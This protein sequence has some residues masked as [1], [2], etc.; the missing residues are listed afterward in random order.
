MDYLIALGDTFSL[1]DIEELARRRQ[2]ESHIVL[3][4]ATG[5]GFSGEDRDRNWLYRIKLSHRAIA[6]KELLGIAYARAKARHLSALRHRPIWRPL[7]QE[8]LDYHERQIERFAHHLS[9]LQL[10]SEFGIGLW[11]QPMSGSDENLL[12]K[13]EDESNGE[14]ARGW[15]VAIPLEGDHT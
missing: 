13:E 4:L 5:W 14:E 3:A 7:T 12:D 15:S 9:V 2:T 6:N 8:Q 1:T 11:S 10:C